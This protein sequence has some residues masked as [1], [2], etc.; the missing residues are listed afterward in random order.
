MPRTAAVRKEWVP[1]TDV[2]SCPHCHQILRAC[3]LPTQDEYDAAYPGL[4]GRGDRENPI[5]LP[6]DADTLDPKQ[7]AKLG[8]LYRC[9][10]CSAALRLG[11]QPAPGAS[12]PDDA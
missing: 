5:P 2:P 8:G 3:Y 10:N 1:P 11:G 12:E 6:F 9:T 4:T 7:R